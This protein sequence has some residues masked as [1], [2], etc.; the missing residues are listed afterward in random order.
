[1][2]NGIPQGMQQQPQSQ[3]SL[4][5][6]QFME[7]LKNNGVNITY[8]QYLSMS[9]QNQTALTAKVQEYVQRRLAAQQAN[10][11]GAQQT[12]QVA[13]QQ[14]QTFMQQAQRNALHQPG[15]TMTPEQQRNFT[16][17]RQ[18]VMNAGADSEMLRQQL[19]SQ[20]RMATERDVQAM[21]QQ[22]LL[23]RQQAAAVAA[24][25]G[26]GQQPRLQQT[27]SQNLKLQTNQPMT[28]INAQQVQL[29]RAQQLRNQA[30]QRNQALNAQNHS[31]P[32]PN[33]MPVSFQQ[34]MNALSPDQ[35]QQ[36]TALDGQVQA[37]TFQQW[38]ARQQSHVQQIP[39]QPGPQL[40]YNPMTAQSMPGTARISG[41][42][43]GMTQAQGTTNGGGPAM[44]RQSTSGGGS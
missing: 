14:A 17:A 35:K 24:Q 22:Q 33:M 4:S 11:P 39:Q 25:N 1:M 2:M 34:F 8:E 38:L 18:Q 16:Q 31:I 5:I 29:Y 30:V 19:T 32:N 20:G 42:M 27:M 3:Q 26:Q 12:V 28:A 40:Q 23:A 7:A 44:M 43:V 10:Q 13:Y 21:F 37:H 15:Q 36:F 9:P 6:T 41:Q